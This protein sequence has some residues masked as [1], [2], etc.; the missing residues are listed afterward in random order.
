MSQKTRWKTAE[1]INSNLCPPQE[2]THVCTHMYKHMTT[3]MCTYLHIHCAYTH[4]VHSCTQ[5]CMHIK[6]KCKTRGRLC[7]VRSGDGR[8]K[9]RGNQEGR[10]ENIPGKKA[11]PQLTDSQHN[12]NS[13]SPLSL[14]SLWPNDLLSR[15]SKA[16][17]HPTLSPIPLTSCLG[18]N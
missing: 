17:P 9:E 18:G 10:K 5:A 11:Q 2:Q 14:Q 4:N 13:S 7:V 12:P 8:G 3:H 1:D 16:T 6:Q 15:S